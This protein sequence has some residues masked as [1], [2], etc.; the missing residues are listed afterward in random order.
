MTD[1]IVTRLREK[2]WDEWLSANPNLQNLAKPLLQ[3]STT[4]WDEFHV[5][6][7][8]VIENLERNNND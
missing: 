1:D 5:G 4:D 8:S 6:W 3:L 7:I 2:D